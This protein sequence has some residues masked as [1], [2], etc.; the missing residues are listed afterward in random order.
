[1]WTQGTRW[2]DARRYDRTDDLPLDRSGDVVHANMM[3]PSAE[4]DARGFSPPCS[5]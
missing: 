4:C 3:I 5:L 1:M 2:I